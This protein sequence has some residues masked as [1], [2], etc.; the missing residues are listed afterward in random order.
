MQAR[1]FELYI[2][3]VNS[4][5][6]SKADLGQDLGGAKFFGPPVEYPQGE[7]RKAICV[8]FLHW[9]EQPHIATLV[10]QF[11]LNV[12]VVPS[13]VQQA[14]IT[15]VLATQSSLLGGNSVAMNTQT[16]R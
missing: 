9:S 10:V 2:K 11:G 6:V 8:N 16:E 12:D 4:T 5:E 13:S 15:P 7:N 3:G 14:P 1:R